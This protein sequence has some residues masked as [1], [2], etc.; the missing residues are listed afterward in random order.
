MKRTIIGTMLMLSA[1]LSAAQADTWVFRDTLRPN[2][3]D[4]SMAVKRADGRRC[5]ASHKCLPPV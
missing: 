4:R 5:G 1:T 2:G 3:H